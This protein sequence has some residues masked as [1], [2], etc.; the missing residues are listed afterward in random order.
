MLLLI[1]VLW[2]EIK[3]A[4]NV[5]GFKLVYLKLSLFTDFIGQWLI[6]TLTAD[7]FSTD[8]HTYLHTDLLPHCTDTV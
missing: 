4:A 3:T 1:R 8:N 2:E 7:Q 5:F 6:F